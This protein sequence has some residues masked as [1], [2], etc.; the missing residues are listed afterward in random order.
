[1]SSETPQDPDADPAADTQKVFAAA[2]QHDLRSLR[3]LLRTVS[4]SVQD[5]ETGSTPL[6]AAIAGA[7]ANN[8]PQTNGTS[9][10]EDV[11]GNVDEKDT[12]EVAVETVKLL[13]QNGAIWNDLDNNDETPGCLALRFGLTDLYKIMVDAGVRAEILLNRLDEYEQL[14]DNDSAGGSDEA[15]DPAGPDSAPSAESNTTIPDPTNTTATTTVAETQKDPQ[16]DQSTYLSS[17]LSFRPDRILDSSSNSVMMS[18]EADLMSRTA[19]LLAPTG[20]LRILNIGHGMGII[21]TC[22][23]STDPSAQHIVEAH[24]AVL[25]RMREQGWYEKPNVVVHE[26]KWQD[27]LPKLIESGDGGGGGG[28]GEGG[29]HL[30]DAIY[31]DTFAEPYSALRTLFEDF[32]IGLLDEGG[33]WGFFNGMGADR[34]ICYDVYAKVVE[35]DLFEAGFEVDWIGVA[36]PDLETKGEWEGVKRAYWK[37]K[38]YRLPVCRFLG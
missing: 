32:V 22:F 7:A 6:H 19:S 24:P 17:P 12:N 3:T 35:L 25:A 29:S 31:F 21:D 23:Q 33:K 36:V 15:E 2:S 16:P 34:Q 27:V 13:L 20:G 18:W 28:G 30:F 11:N 8:Q 37:L 10:G 38:E 14:K 1:M 4:A 26:G 5:P 9:H